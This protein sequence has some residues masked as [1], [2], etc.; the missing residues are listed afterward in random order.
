[1]RI[2]LPTIKIGRKTKN[3]K[4]KYQDELLLFCEGIKE[5]KS[6]LDFQVSS[7]GWCYLLEEYGLNKGDFD[8][9]QKIINECRKSGLLP[10]DICAEDNARIAEG[11]DAP[12]DSDPENYAFIW[13]DYLKNNLANRYHPYYFS[14]YQ[15][16]YIEMLVEKIDLKGIFKP[17]CEKYSIPIGNTKGWA[18]INS[19]AAMM[20][21]FRE[22]ESKGKQC[23]LLYCGDHDPGGLIISDTI[24]KNLS[25]L[26]KAVNWTP[27]NLVIDRIGLNYDFI[28]ANNLTWISNLETGSSKRL[29][30]KTHND[31]NKPY[32]QNYI[33]QFGARKVEA[34]ALVTRVEEG[35]RLCEE[36]IIKYINF[37]GI[38]IHNESTQEA[39]ELLEKEIEKLIR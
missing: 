12:D 37:D 30:D 19:R 7:R 35:R 32:V 9:A 6:S 11:I 25:D 39:R 23:V 3:D 15:D 16:C 17:I 38:N 5:V 10:L 18:D 29:D 34:N 24:R 14:D 1:M 21:R 27:D 13:V 4:K 31:H 2:T 22:W 20:G 36:A 26:S 28:Q 33:K 8:T